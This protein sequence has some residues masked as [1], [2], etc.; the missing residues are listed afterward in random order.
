VVEEAVEEAVLVPTGSRWYSDSLVLKL[1]AVLY[2]L[3]LAP[4]LADLLV[5]GFVW[6]RLPTRLPMLIAVAEGEC[7][8]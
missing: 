4:L 2:L 3:V 1:T 7:S 5:V 8:P 6:M